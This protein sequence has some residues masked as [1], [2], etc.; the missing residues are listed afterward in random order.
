MRDPLIHLRHSIN[1]KGKK[2]MKLKLWQ[3]E[4]TTRWRWKLNGCGFCTFVN[5][6]MS[7]GVW[8]FICARKTFLSCFSANYPHRRRRWHRWHRT[9]K[10]ESYTIF[11]VHHGNSQAPPAIGPK[12]SSRKKNRRK[13]L[14]FRNLNANWCQWMEDFVN[15]NINWP[16][17]AHSL[18][19]KSKSN[20][21]C[22]ANTNC[23]VSKLSARSTICGN[24]LVRHSKNPIRRKLIS[25]EMRWAKTA[26]SK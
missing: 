15:A 24:H 17:F 7:N 3:K 12:F 10:L 20:D 13:K 25:R 21:F 14:H 1:W 23:S 26:K 9:S 5:A 19:M 18:P 4:K 16:R 2:Q 8:H 22:A 6:S 11:M